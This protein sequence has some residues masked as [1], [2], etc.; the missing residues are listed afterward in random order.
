MITRRFVLTGLIAAPAVIAAD[1][2]MK[3]HSLP[4]RYATVYGVGWDFEV[5]E[6]PIW[7]PMSVAYFG[8][9][10]AIDQFREVTAFVHAFPVE[11][12]PETYNN[13]A[14][15]KR[16]GATFGIPAETISTREYGE[17]AIKERTKQIA[18]W[19]KE[20]VKDDGFTRIMGFDEI[21]QW[22]EAQ[23]PDLDGRFSVEWTQEQLEG[24]RKFGGEPSWLTDGLKG[25][26][27]V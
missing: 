27:D 12:M 10:P 20:P 19:Q 18:Y 13:S 8:G 16:Y 15:L 2:L 7:H 23:R 14:Y 22:R 17:H 11:P 24:Y 4:E 26:S 3:V 9:T 6:H 5:I 21:D 25:K 1:K